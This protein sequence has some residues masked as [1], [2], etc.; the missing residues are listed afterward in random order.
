MDG[1]DTEQIIRAKLDGTFTRVRDDGKVVTQVVPLD[2]IPDHQK[3]ALPENHGMRGPG[4]GIRHLWTAEEDVELVE[5][6][7][8]GWSKM[9]CALHFGASE[10]SVRRRIR[11]LRDREKGMIQ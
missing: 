1:E 6:R 10:D 5:L 8:Q 7:R 2:Y 11:D 3:K 9:R 4:K